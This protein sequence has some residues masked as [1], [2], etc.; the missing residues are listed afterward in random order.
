MIGDSDFLGLF[1]APD[2]GAIWGLTL[3][4]VR[5]LFF[6]MPAI[7]LGLL[8]LRARVAE[9]HRWLVWLASGNVAAVFLMNLSFN[10]W[11]GGVTTGARYQIVALPFW[12]LLVALLPRGR[13][14]TVA[15]AVLGVVSVLNMGVIAATSPMAPDGLRGSPL[16][17]VWAKLIGVA[18]VDLGLAAP[19]EAGGPLSRGSLHIY[20]SFLLRDWPIALTD[21]LIARWGSFNLGERLLGLRGIWSLLP[22]AAFAGSVLAWAAR[23][24]RGAP[25]GEAGR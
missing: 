13:R 20:P 24:A 8:T 1:R 16:L 25:A 18:Q 12:V 15:L 9:E 11:Q 3:S 22:I 2:W 17:F 23:L 10:A 4:P 5:G 19:P 14:L 6:F 21:H 7:T